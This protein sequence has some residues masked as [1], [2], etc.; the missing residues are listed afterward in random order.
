MEPEQGD[1]DVA[2]DDDLDAGP[3][4]PDAGEPAEVVR[5]EVA[6]RLTTRCE[7]LD[8]GTRRRVGGDLGRRERGEHAGARVVGPGPAEPDDDA[9]GAGVARGPQQLA[10]AAGRRPARV[11]AVG[12]DEVQPA[13]LR[14]LDVGGDDAV[15]T[16]DDEQP[17]GH[18][19]PERPRHGDGL[20]PAVRQRRGEHLDEAG[21]AV[22]E[23]AQVEH[24]VRRVPA[25]ALRERVRRPAARSGCR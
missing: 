5:G 3:V 9:V 12:R 19:L 11:P 1:V 15:L 24:V 6:Q 10:D 14:R 20:Q 21:P 17:G 25:P 18:R 2:G 8:D 16:G 23:R 7:P 22:G 4:R 13:R